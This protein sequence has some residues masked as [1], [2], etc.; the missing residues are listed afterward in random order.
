MKNDKLR[1]WQDRLKQN[2]TAYANELAKMDKR[3]LLYKGDRKL[4]DIVVGEVKTSA[5]H[6][7][8][9]VAELIEA[10]VDSS[11]PQPK[12]TAR[13]EKDQHLAKIIEDMLRNE[14]D[15]LPF[16]MMNDQMERTVP[17]QGS[18]DWL[19]EWD[20]TKR[21]HT[22]IGELAVTTLH[23][24]QVIP[25]DGVYTG[26]EDMDYIIVK[27]PQTKTFIE[28]RYG[29]SLE[30]E[31]ESEPEVKGV[32]DA[33]AND[34]VTQYIAYYRN[35]KGG[36]GKY[37]WVN[38][39]QLEDMEDYQA[40]RLRRC[41]KC[42]QIMNGDL[43]PMEPTPDGTA[44]IEERPKKANACPYCGSTS[45]EESTEEFEEL[46]QDVVKTDG[47]VIPAYR[48]DVQP[49][50]DETGLPVIDPFTG[51]PATE[52]VR[53][54]TRIPFYKPDV[55]PVLQQKSVSMYGSFGGDSDVDKIEDQQN[56]TN[57]LEAKVIDKLLKSGSYMTLPDDCYIEVDAQD[58]K[59]IR[60]KDPAAMSMI[61]VYDLQGNIQQDAQYLLQVY[62]EA[63]QQIGITDSFQ[64]RR[65][66]T[67]TSGK[68]REFAAAQS[69]GRLE[70]K[71]R[72]KDAAY[73]ALYEAMFKF[74]L[75]YT[76]EPR[77]VVSTDKHGQPVYESFN[78]YDFC[79]QDRSVPLLLRFFLRPCEQPRGDVAGDA[80]EPAERRVRRPAEH[81][82]ADPVLDKD[83]HAP[84]SRRGRHAG[85]PAGDARPAADAAAADDDATA[86]DAEG[87]DGTAGAAER[88][89][90][91]H[92]SGGDHRRQTRRTTGC[93]GKSPCRYEQKLEGRRN[94]EWHSITSPTAA[95][96]LSKLSSSR[97][98]RRARPRCRRAR[99]SA[100]ASNP[101]IIFAGEKR[102]N[103]RK[104][105]P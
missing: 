56:T 39:T 77:P 21:T 80:H 9:I 28:R 14:I 26:I 10:Q 7:R 54:P 1:M 40:R 71:R 65:D 92:E 59:V 74:K 95:P 20:N 55:Y 91:P 73:A 4:R 5:V 41:K 103:R 100:P 11:I 32:A 51:L 94:R 60:P 8:N 27:V 63:R 45:F 48:E 38:D 36:I 102:K 6:V 98:P 44:P 13:Y 3:E 68:A 67:A 24:K 82:H 47:S 49:L 61:G 85:I 58:M 46:T 35:D 57:R 79:Q 89:P 66:T 16:E 104:E 87:A 76:D 90:E 23:P 105:N 83:V 18:G 33:E 72:M 17:I 101:S 97:R 81:Q 70:S 69:A 34:L 78:K 19:V 93:K 22:T 52:V 12:V 86:D 99:T 96:R 15:R 84:L 53:T 42:G 50:M 64:G 2:E 62:E 75:A 30:D 31:R 88:D 25:Q 29:V 37:S 43:Q